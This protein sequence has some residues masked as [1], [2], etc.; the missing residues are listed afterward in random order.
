MDVVDI[1]FCVFDLHNIHI[2]INSWY[3]LTLAER[4][5]STEC[6]L[7]RLLSERNGNYSYLTQCGKFAVSTLRKVRFKQHSFN[8]TTIVSLTRI[9]N[10]PTKVKIWYS[11]LFFFLHRLMRVPRTFINILINTS[12]AEFGLCVDL[13]LDHQCDITV[14]FRWDVQ[15][16]SS[17][18]FVAVKN[19]CE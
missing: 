1:F 15:I 2:S 19:V 14:F 7:F 3:I 10:M 4:K 11:L 9:L 6:P 5:H 16:V 17:A 13:W 18:L 12:R 8:A